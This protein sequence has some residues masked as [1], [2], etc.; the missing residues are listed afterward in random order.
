MNQ[1]ENYLH[2]SNF[3]RQAG[4]PTVGNEFPLCNLKSLFL[5]WKRKAK[6]RSTGRQAWP[7][8]EGQAAQLRAQEAFWATELPGKHGLDFTAE[9]CKK[10]KSVCQMPNSLEAFLKGFAEKGLFCVT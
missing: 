8:A 10:K 9:S 1:C 4:R 5:A 7:K 6:G 3:Y 2:E